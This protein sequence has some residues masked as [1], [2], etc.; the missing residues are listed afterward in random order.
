[1]TFLDELRASRDGSSTTT[2]TI[3]TTSGSF[4]ESLRSSR[5]VEDV[6]QLKLKQEREDFKRLE[7]ER[8]KRDED[9]RKRPLLQRVLETFRPKVKE[10]VQVFE[11]TEEFR[12]TPERLTGPTREDA[13]PVS[14]LEEQVR[15]GERQVAFEKKE[16]EKLLEAVTLA[17]RIIVGDFVKFLTRT[18]LEKTNSDFSIT[19]VSKLE[20][21][22]LGTDNIRRL[23]D[24]SLTY[25]LT[26]QQAEKAGLEEGDQNRLAFGSAIM[27]GIILDNPFSVSLKSILKGSAEK[28]LTKVFTNLLEKEVGAEL[29]EQ[30]VKKIA[31]ETKKII[32]LETKEAR[33]EAAEALLKEMTNN[34]II[35]GDLVSRVMSDNVQESLLSKEALAL[36]ESL[37]L[38]L[39]R[40]DEILDDLVEESLPK[41]KVSKRKVSTKN[42]DDVFVKQINDIIDKSGKA[43]TDAASAERNKLLNVIN[44]VTRKGELKLLREGMRI[45]AKG[46]KAFELLLNKHVTKGAVQKAIVDFATEALPREVRGKFLK[47]VQNAKNN[48]D[49]SA[50]F[51]RIHKEATD[52]QRKKLNAS[53]LKTIKDLDKLPVKEQSEILYLTEKIRFKDF[54]ADNAKKIQASK[55]FLAD[56][57]D[58]ARDVPASLLKKIQDLD[59]VNIND[60]S[61]DQLARLND[62]LQVLVTEGTAKKKARARIKE[63]KKE[64]ILDKMVDESVNI[65]SKSVKRER[66]LGEKLTPKQRATNSLLAIKDNIKDFDMRI[67]FMDRIFDA[68]DGAKNFKGVNYKTFKEPVDKSFNSYIELSENVKDN[69]WGK[70]KELELNAEQFERIGVHAMKMQ[71]NGREKLLN[72]G[73]TQGQI[74]EVVLTPQ[75]MEMYNFMRSELDSIKPALDKVMSDV[76]DFKVDS[77]ENYFPMI[78]D[79]ER[80]N[81][82]LEEV[83]KD[84]KRNSTKKGFT[85][86]RKE[87]AKQAVEINALKS[88]LRHMDDVAYTISMESTL[89]DLGSIARNSKY[90]EAV[91]ETGQKIVTDWLDILARK[92]GVANPNKLP[93]WVNKLRKN[94]SVGIFAFKIGTTLKQ[95]LALFNGAGDIGGGVFKSFSEILTSK[96]KRAF[97]K[98]ASAEIRNRILDDP[99]FVELSDFGKFQ[100]FI[101][102]GL[103]PMQ[104]ADALTA[105]GV[106][107]EA[108]KQELKR[109]GKEFKFDEVVEDAVLFADR[110]VRKT[111]ATSSFKDLPPALV[112]PNRDAT[113]L[114]F[115]FQTF[116]LNNWNQLSK[117]LPKK[118]REDPIKGSQMLFYLSMGY[119]MEDM[120]NDGLYSLVHPGKEKQEEPFTEKAFFTMAQQVPVVGSIVNSTRFD[121]NP[122]P[123]I[124]F[125]EN[126]LGS[127]DRIITGKKESTKLRG[128]VGAI[129]SAAILA[130]VP[131]A[132]QTGQIIRGKLE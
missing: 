83:S 126:L 114:F 103:F 106:W 57:P 64:V 129:E 108:Y 62:R 30:G 9:F 21:L 124:N 27:A 22:A 50:A 70:F 72:S 11:T 127:V 48:A 61:L 26:K 101:D 79:F 56:N 115:Q 130:G 2:T 23:R 32:K 89:K 31:K 104:R 10:D 1:M 63:A 122:I 90:K 88:Y 117:D 19:P 67:T 59:K 35:K 33:Q 25:Q 110:T 45:R 3:P 36:R 16:D 81:N 74:D 96:E 86:A 107:M 131:G 84:F 132:S 14:A 60:L 18:G 112:G 92:G 51:R 52:I 20:E 46:A 120:I 111:Q 119:A 34:E 113:K 6:K 75:E 77:N 17:P 54:T 71:R 37:D 76:H 87:G 8:I 55:N 97:V 82:I 102:V 116:A 69:F 44:Q 38:K 128:L 49:L 125:G 41:P 109:L 15:K 5:E 93:D 53:V 95:P 80:S 68:L 13:Q 12:R 29:N 73:L 78:T 58:V 121:S 85:I 7:E 66:V 105:S 99:G 4:L 39:T 65:D 28:E 47:A 123:L 100:E 98:K 118:F 94:T 43:V 24:D 40:S 42:V 91:G